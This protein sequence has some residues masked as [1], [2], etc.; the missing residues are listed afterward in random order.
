VALN[1]QES[2]RSSMAREMRAM[3]FFVHKR[4]MSI[5]KKAESVSDRTSYIIL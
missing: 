2:T 1:Q 3:N 4:F 5:V